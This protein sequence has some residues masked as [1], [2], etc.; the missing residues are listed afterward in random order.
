M[1]NLRNIYKC[2]KR[3]NGGGGRREAHLKIQN[4]V[5]L[6]LKRNIRCNHDRL[7]KKFVRS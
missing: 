6:Q 1:R 2:S 5:E 7:N 4:T 3:Y